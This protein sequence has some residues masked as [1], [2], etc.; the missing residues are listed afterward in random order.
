MGLE[1]EVSRSF[2]RN[3][4]LS[5]SVVSLTILGYFSSPQSEDHRP[6][7]LTP[8]LARII[9]YQRSAQKWILR[10]EEVN[11]ELAAIQEQNSMDLFSQDRQLS[12][13]YGWLVALREEM[14]GTDAPATLVNLHAILL[15]VVDRYMQATAWTAKW[16]S[17]PT[18]ENHSE[19]IAVWYAASQQLLEILENP[20]LQVG[21]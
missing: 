3:I 1:L 17:E 21:P 15:D 13:V 14:D 20:W 11:A 7:L 5:V 16:A 9:Q 19:A 8:S 12:R 18:E 4:F 10:I 2:L 6:M